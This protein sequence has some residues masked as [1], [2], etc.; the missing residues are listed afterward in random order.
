MIR[1]DSETA[2]RQINVVLGWSE[3]VRRKIPIH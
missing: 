1:A 3:E 2:Y